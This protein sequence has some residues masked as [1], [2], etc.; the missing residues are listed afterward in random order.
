MLF[1]YFWDSYLIG[2]SSF[3]SYVSIKAENL[4]F[5]GW[6]IGFFFICT[7]E[8]NLL[9]EELTEMPM[10]LSFWFL[11]LKIL[12]LRFLSLRFLSF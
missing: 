2:V 5:Y 9:V 3:R 4:L 11:S 1:F 12:S 8:R 7:L 6:E 10:F